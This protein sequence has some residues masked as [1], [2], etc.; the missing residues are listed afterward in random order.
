MSKV[1]SQK[2]YKTMKRLIIK[3]DMKYFTN[4]LEHFYKQLNAI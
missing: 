1:A 3:L 2:Y 4:T